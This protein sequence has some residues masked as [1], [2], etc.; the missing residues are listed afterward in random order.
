MYRWQW[1]PL[2]CIVA[3]FIAT[4]AVLVVHR[5]R[6]L[7]ANRRHALAR[8][9]LR[10]PGESMRDPMQDAAWDAAEYAALGLFLVPLVFC[11]FPLKLVWEGE[12]PGRETTAVYA[13]AAAFGLL[14]ILARLARVLGRGRSL[15]LGYEAE[16]AVGQELDELRHLG[17]RVF[18]DVPAEGLEAHIDHIVVGPAGVF[19]V[20]ARGRDAD[21]PNGRDQAWEV[22]YDGESLQ[23]PGWK[24]TLPLGQAMRQAEWLFEWIEEV[25]R[26]PVAVRPILVLPGWSVKR[27]AVSGIPVLAARRIQ[28][29]F[30]RMRPRPEMTETM[31]ER[32]A[33]QIDR[34][35]RV[36]ALVGPPAA[37]DQG[38]IPISA[39]S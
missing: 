22:T 16:R 17:Y 2:L 37:E 31:I 26:E 33:E 34:S 6:A 9:L 24:E 38:T 13:G 25:I 18:H 19:A 35:C 15:A 32:I 39:V 10:G 11:V 4:L 20:A 23:F 7:V 28:A 21:R 27:T 5:R 12:L 3:S 36:V 14:C 8:D 1:F 30:Q 29:Y